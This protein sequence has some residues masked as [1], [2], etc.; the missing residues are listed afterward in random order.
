MAAGRGM[1][2]I[3]S[4]RERDGAINSCRERDGGKWGVHFEV[5][6]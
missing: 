3:N 2:A 1:G 4:C 6:L 5:L